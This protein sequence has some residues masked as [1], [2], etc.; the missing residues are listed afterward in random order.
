MSCSGISTGSGICF[1]FIAFA[2]RLAQDCHSLNRTLALFVPVALSLGGPNLGLATALAVEWP[3][4]VVVA[5]QVDSVR[6]LFGDVC[7]NGTKRKLQLL[8][9]RSWQSR[10]DWATGFV[11]SHDLT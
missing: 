10:A 5:N 6:T 4:D 11:L 8:H 2:T 7:W 3:V 1:D 9:F